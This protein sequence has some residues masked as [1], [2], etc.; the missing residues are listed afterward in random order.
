MDHHILLHWALF[1]ARL[2]QVQ[3]ANESYPPETQLFQLMQRVMIGKV[4][5]G[6]TFDGSSKCIFFVHRGLRQEDVPQEDQEWLSSDKVWWPGGD[7][8][9]HV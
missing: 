8:G 2:F 6:I 1:V 9:Q 3:I 5:T 4:N 7:S